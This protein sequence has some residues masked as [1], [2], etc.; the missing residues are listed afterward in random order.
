[1][2]KF[3]LDFNAKINGLYLNSETMDMLSIIQ[4]NN[5]Q[6]LKDFALNCSQLNISREEMQIS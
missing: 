6:E 5:L 3:F 4:C 2:K 1:M